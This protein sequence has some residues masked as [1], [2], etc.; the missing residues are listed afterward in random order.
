MKKLFLFISLFFSFCVFAQIEKVIPAKPNPSRLVNNYTNA[1][2]SQQV[3]S[4][5]QKL[6]TYDDST[7]NQLVVVVMETT[8]S[9][10]IEDVALGILRTWGVGNKGK[11]NGVVILATIKDRKVWIATGSGLEGAVPDITAKAIINNDI[12]PAFRTGDYYKGF[13][14]GTTSLIKAAAGEYNAP[15]GYANRGTKPGG[16]STITIIVIIF[17]FI[18]FG[19]FGRGKGGGGKYIS[20]GGHGWFF[21]FFMGG[22]LGGGMGGGG[23]GTG[24]GGMGGGFGG[25]GGGGGMGG[26]AGGGW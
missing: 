14:A 23:R 11:N 20:R 21:P 2:T 6:V 3:Q 5:E 1:L 15:E 4:L 13:D 25:F 9:Y 26:G 8:G 12:L 10:S 18:I 24:G 7:S 16:V 17:L 22:M 19:M